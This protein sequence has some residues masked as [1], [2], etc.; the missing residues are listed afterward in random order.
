MMFFKA[1]PALKA[2]QRE[3][4][5]IV[6]L[7]NR[8]ASALVEYEER[9]IAGWHTTLTRIHSFLEVPIAALERGTYCVTFDHEAEETLRE[10]RWMR[11]LNIAIPSTAESL[12]K[13]TALCTAAR[14]LS[15][16]FSCFE[17]VRAKIPPLPKARWGIW[18]HMLRPSCAPLFRR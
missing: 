8:I 18:W 14:R 16:L 13:S 9:Y 17:E 5:K 15:Y 3:T 6:R 7:Y 4:M 2:H 10:I 1:S 12:A 11:H